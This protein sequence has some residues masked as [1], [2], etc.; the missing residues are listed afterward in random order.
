[1]VVNSAV[2]LT[3]NVISFS[4]IWKRYN[5]AWKISKNESRKMKKKEEK[6]FFFLGEITLAIKIRVKKKGF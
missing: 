4:F 5:A 1:M 3:N 6:N 2:Y